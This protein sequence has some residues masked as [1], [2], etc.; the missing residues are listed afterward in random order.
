MERELEREKRRPYISLSVKRKFLERKI[1][2]V[3][4][5]W[6]GRGVKHTLG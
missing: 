4:D 1:I 6:W 5:N 2:T 3:G